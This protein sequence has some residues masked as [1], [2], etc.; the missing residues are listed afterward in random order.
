MQVHFLYFKVISR[1]PTVVT[2]QPAF[3]HQDGIIKLT[4]GHILYALRNCLIY[5]HLNFCI[6]CPR[7]T[8]LYKYE[9]VSS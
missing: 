5:P 4:C 3:L 7:F 1:M 9:Y 6:K 8:Q 2:L